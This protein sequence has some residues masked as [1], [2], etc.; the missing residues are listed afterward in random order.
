M[1]SATGI[2]ALPCERSFSCEQ[3]LANT[4]CMYCQSTEK[5]LVFPVAR[6]G[7]VSWSSCP[8]NLSALYW[9]SCHLSYA[10][11]LA[12]AIAIFVFVGFLLLCVC[13]LCVLR[14]RCNRID[15]GGT[16]AAAFSSSPNFRPSLTYHYARRLVRNSFT[17]KDSPESD[18]LLGS[19]QFRRSYGPT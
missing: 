18:R 2:G 11:F 7:M 6:L 1:V 10:Y 3:C 16:T 19:P 8:P 4:S 13:V 14:R 12:L 17:F 9:Y 15:L 5:C